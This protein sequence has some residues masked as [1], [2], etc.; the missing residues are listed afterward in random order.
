VIAVLRG[1]HLE[2]TSWKCRVTAATL[3]EWRDRF[4]AAGEAG[5][6]TCEMDV[7]DEERRRFKS[8]SQF[9]LCCP[10]PDSCSLIGLRFPWRDC[11]PPSPTTQALRI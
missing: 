5:L 9:S 3:A 11:W 7:D 1:A 6:K 2:F 4:L 8:R 10:L